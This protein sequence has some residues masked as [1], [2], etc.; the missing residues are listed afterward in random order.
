MYA[1]KHAVSRNARAGGPD[2]DSKSHQPLYW[3]A[4]IHMAGNQ[5]MDKKAR[6][7]RDKKY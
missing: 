1:Q 5:T 7:P 6:L 2:H 3:R 4:P